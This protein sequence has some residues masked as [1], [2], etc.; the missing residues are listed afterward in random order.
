M[1]EELTWR[2]IG[3]VTMPTSQWNPQTDARPSIRYVDVSGVSRDQL[4]IVSVADHSAANAPGRARKVV[5]AGDTIFATVRPTLRRI[6][7]I[8][9]SLDGEIVSTAFCVLR[10]N[11]SVIHPDFLYFAMQ[12]ESVTDSIAAMQTGASYPAVR[13]TDVFG[14]A[15]PLPS[16]SDQQDIAATL[17]LVRSALLGEENREDVAMD[18]KRAAM[19]TLFTRGLR[20]EAQK[21]TEIGVGAGELG[22]DHTR[23]TVPRAKRGHSDGAIWKPTTQGRLSRGRNT[24]GEPNSYGLWTN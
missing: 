21:E 22:Q 7:Q 12:H 23:R 9:A 16:L 2:L 8:P 20:G 5:K 4:K 18:L 14:Q 13:D 15:V 3:E 6:A 19:H 11:P 10:P 17:N 1:N 24:R